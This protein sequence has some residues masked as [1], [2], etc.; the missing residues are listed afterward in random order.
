MFPVV[1]ELH[2]VAQL[3]V[4]Y[5]S[6]AWTIDSSTI[7]LCYAVVMQLMILRELK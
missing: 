1:F 4:C 3:V 7:G 6:R 2:Y 5:M